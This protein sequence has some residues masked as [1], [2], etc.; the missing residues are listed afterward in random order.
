MLDQW[1][2]T[3]LAAMVGSFAGTPPPAH[4][5]SLDRV[6]E[7]AK[8]SEPGMS[9]SFIAFPARLSAVRIILLYSCAAIPP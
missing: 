5:A 2:S 3:E 9:I 4:L 7:N 8:A 1:K 6:V